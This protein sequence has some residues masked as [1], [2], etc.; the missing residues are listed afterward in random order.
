[1]EVLGIHCRKRYCRNFVFEGRMIATAVYNPVWANAHSTAIACQV[2]FDEL[3]DVIPFAATNYD[4]EPYG[5]QLF[6]DLVNGVYGP[7]AP[8]VP[9]LP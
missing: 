5:R 1:M 8:Y 6:T 9:P 7:I 2:K 4:P 3:P